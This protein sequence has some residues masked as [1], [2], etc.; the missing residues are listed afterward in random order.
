MRINLFVW[1]Y[2]TEK[3]ASFIPAKFVK[4]LQQMLKDISAPNELPSYIR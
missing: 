3:L 2:L 1:G 4:H